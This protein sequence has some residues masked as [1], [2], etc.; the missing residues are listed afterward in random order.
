MRYAFHVRRKNGEQQTELKI[1]QGEPPKAGS[2]FQVTLGHAMVF[3]R[4]AAVTVPASKD[5]DDPVL[6]VHADEL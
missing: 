5:G 6:E 4:V 2:R 3:V 1:H